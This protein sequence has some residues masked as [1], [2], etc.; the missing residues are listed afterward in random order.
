ML[1][2]LIEVVYAGQGVNFMN[3][4]EDNNLSKIRWRCR[5][6]LLELDVMLQTFCDKVYPNLNLEK[7]Q[8]FAELLEEEDQDLQRWLTG[9]QPCEKPKLQD[10]LLVIRHM[11]SLAATV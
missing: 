1:V 7:Q 3:N 4:E 5:R 6:G 9:G 10:M 8:L 11:H 2:F